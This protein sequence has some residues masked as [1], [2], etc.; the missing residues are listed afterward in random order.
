MVPGDDQ[1][2]EEA[3]MNIFKAADAGVQNFEPLQVDIVIP[4]TSN[5]EVRPLC[6][7]IIS[8]AYTMLINLLFGFKIQYYNGTVLHKRE[9][10]QSVKI[11]TNSFFYQAEALIKLLRQGKTYVEARAPIKERDGGTTKAFSFKNI[12]TVVKDILRLRFYG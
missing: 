7:R 5:Q 11:E 3:M 10:I 6:R 12:Y 4:Y 8:K 9:L 1:L 2:I